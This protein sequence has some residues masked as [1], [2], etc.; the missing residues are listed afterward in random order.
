MKASGV[1]P[2]SFARAL[3]E[4]LNQSGDARVFD[5]GRTACMASV[6]RYS[7]FLA[8]MHN[9]YS[10][11]E[12]ELDR[13][14][15]SSAAV[16]RVWSRHGDTLR[17]APALQSELDEVADFTA[18]AA[19]KQ[20][21]PT[22]RYVASVREAAASDRKTGGARL[23]GHLYCRYRADLV[24]G[25]KLAAC[26]RAALR[27]APEAPRQYMCE[28]PAETERSTFLEGVCESFDEAGSM[29]AE[30]HFDAAVIEAQQAIEHTLAVYSEEPMYFDAFRGGLNVCAVLLAD[31]VRGK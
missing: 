18:Y 3:D 15:M 20:S 16:Q 31:K 6:T 28:L 5:L 23:L 29:L 11:M 8:S 14:A 1:G 30:E 25:E 27:L 26:T 7:R 2:G 19:A 4:A 24:D 21:P 12:E 13:T 9:V 17:R 10:A 22:S